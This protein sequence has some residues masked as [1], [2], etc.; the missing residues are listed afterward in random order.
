MTNNEFYDLLQNKFDLADRDS[1]SVNTNV[2]KLIMQKNILTKYN[3]SGNLQLYAS[4]P[5]SN[6]VYPNYANIILNTTN[7][8]NSKTDLLNIMTSF[9]SN[10]YFITNYMYNESL[11]SSNGVKMIDLSR[12]LDTPNM[13]WNWNVGRSYNDK[14]VKDIAN[15]YIS[16]FNE[17]IDYVITNDL[18]KI[19]D[20]FNKLFTSMF[21]NN[22]NKIYSHSNGTLVLPSIVNWLSAKRGDGLNNSLDYCGYVAKDSKLFPSAKNTNWSTQQKWSDKEQVVSP[23][24]NVPKN[25]NN[26]IT[27]SKYN[28]PFD[29]NVQ[30]PSNVVSTPIVTVNNL[31]NVK[32]N[33]VMNE[34]KNKDGSVNKIDK[35]DYNTSINNLNNLKYA[36]QDKGTKVTLKITV[37]RTVKD[38]LTVKGSTLGEKYLYDIT[39][40]KYVTTCGE[41]NADAGG[42]KCT[43]LCSRG[44]KRAYYPKVNV[45]NSSD[46]KIYTL[47][48][49][50]EIEDKYFST[51]INAEQ[52]P[53]AKVIKIENKQIRIMG[54]GNVENKQY[55]S[56]EDCNKSYY[57]P[58]NSTER[59]SWCWCR[60]DE[61]R[62]SRRCGRTYPLS[63]DYEK[64]PDINTITATAMVTFEY[65]DA[66]DGNKYTGSLDSATDAVLN[67][68][69]T[70]NNDKAICLY[71]TNMDLYF[72][73]N[74]TF[75]H[76]VNVIK[77]AKNQQLI[78]DELRTY[79]KEHLELI[80]LN[81]IN[82]AFGPYIQSLSSDATFINIPI[83]PPLLTIPNS[84]VAEYKNYF[85]TF[86]INNKIDNSMVKYDMTKSSVNIINSISCNKSNK[87]KNY[88]DVSFSNIISLSRYLKSIDKSADYL[89]FVLPSKGYQLFEV[90]DKSIVTIAS[91]DLI[92]GYDSINNTKSI[93]HDYN[94]SKIIVSF[95]D[96]STNDKLKTLLSNYNFMTSVNVP[97]IEIKQNDEFVDLNINTLTNSTENKVYIYV[98]SDKTQ[99]L[100][101]RLKGNG[102]DDKDKN[103]DKNKINNEMINILYNGIDSNN[104]PMCLQLH[105]I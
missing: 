47:K 102:I 78:L 72:F 26:L 18:K 11:K 100:I 44:D 103:V 76:W 31:T 3:C 51:A 34:I 65:D 7:V 84:Y 69:T 96:F 88:L 64:L 21:I 98:S 48:K 29:T 42:K 20:K 6:K 17:L 75:S 94:S 41:Y 36:T 56:S 52:Y 93:I 66:F 35:Y 95:V 87:S 16:K 80:L 67:D 30:N 74:I 70:V 32:I 55:V 15:F 97:M 23:I 37:R 39:T 5:K 85:P 9:I 53:N 58:Y 86:T 90:I 27:M 8:A 25:I 1:Y 62:S 89:Y 92:S 4:I 46:I 43:T 104:T 83:G 63:E 33:Y 99:E 22:E 79:I 50:S 2:I 45:E 40:K 71:K 59:V 73:S 28:Y 68:K 91:N 54:G 61:S 13:C 57:K 14:T 10:P 38:I 49:G 77:Q 105:F 24:I 12:V 82:I 19:D 60:D 81:K 101:S